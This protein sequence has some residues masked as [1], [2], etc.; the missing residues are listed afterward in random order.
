MMKALVALVLTVMSSSVFASQQTITCY[1][2][3]NSDI[4]MEIIAEGDYNNIMNVEI[5]SVSIYNMDWSQLPE[6]QRQKV[7]GQYLNNDINFDV[8]LADGTYLL[9]PQQVFYPGR[10]GSI[11]VNGKDEY[12]CFDYKN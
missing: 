5:K 6:S 12:R 1:Y 7:T 9:V 4:N 10:D 11:Y 2:T 3:S 8:R